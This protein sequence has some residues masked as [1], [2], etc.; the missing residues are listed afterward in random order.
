MPASPQEEVVYDRLADAR[1][2]SFDQTRRTGQLLFKTVLEKSLFSSPAACLETI[3][4]RLRKIEKE[5]GAEADKDR[6]TLGG[7]AEA[8]ERVGPD[9]LSKYRRL[10][11]ILEPGGSL[12]WNPDNPADRIVLFTER[13]ETLRFLE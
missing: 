10:V 8:I 1:F 2:L 6:V 4:Q 3:R 7:I 13:I 12:H 9:K 11:K 5:T